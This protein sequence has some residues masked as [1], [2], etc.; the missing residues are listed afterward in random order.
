MN[1]SHKMDEQAQIAF[2]APFVVSPSSQSVSILF[3]LLCNATV[4]LT[5]STDCFPGVAQTDIQKVPGLRVGIQIPQNRIRPN[6]GVSHGFGNRIGIRWNAEKLGNFSSG[7]YREVHC[8]NARN[9]LM[10]ISSPRPGGY[11][12]P[13]NSQ[14]KDGRKFCQT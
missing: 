14:D 1:V 6:G 11:C 5:A 10:P 2:A 8:R 13:K 7:G 3:D 9:N 4:S 12:R